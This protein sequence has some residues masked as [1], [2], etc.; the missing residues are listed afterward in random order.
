MRNHMNRGRK[1]LLT[2]FAVSA[3]AA[4]TLTGLRGWGC[5]GRHR[6]SSGG[7]EIGVLC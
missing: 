4:L 1:A 7:E 2:T 3:V 5:A 6:R